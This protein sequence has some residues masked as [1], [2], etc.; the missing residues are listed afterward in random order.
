M[1][2]ILLIVFGS[3]LIFSALCCP[4]NYDFGY[5][6]CIFGVQY[7]DSTCTQFT[8]Q[9]CYEVYCTDSNDGEFST[10]NY[11]TN[12]I[13][14]LWSICTQQCCDSSV[15]YLQNADSI[16]QCQDYLNSQFNKKLGMGLG[17]AFGAI[18]LIAVI[19]C[20]CTVKR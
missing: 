2:T 3:A 16:R 18:F 12:N 8:F 13:S 10:C 17:I 1:R 19:A 7:T 4:T 20:Y 11:Q 6:S 14:T 9:R 5:S 15:S